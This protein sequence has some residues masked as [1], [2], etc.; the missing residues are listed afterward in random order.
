MRPIPGAPRTELLVA[1]RPDNSSPA[2][3]GFLELE[4]NVGVR[5]AKRSRRARLV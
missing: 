5:R 1:W 3:R 2:L 4:R